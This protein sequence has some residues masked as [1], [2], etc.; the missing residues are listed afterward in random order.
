MFNRHQFFSL[1]SCFKVANIG[2][3]SSAYPAMHLCVS[4][5]KLGTSSSPATPGTFFERANPGHPGNFFVYFPAPGQKMM[6]KFPG[7]GAKFSQ[8]PRIC[9]VLSLQKSLKIKK[10]TRQQNHS[11]VFKYSSLDIQLKQWN[12]HIH[13]YIVLNA[14]VH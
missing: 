13:K 8:T 10:T 12:I 11:K 3:L 4:Q 14:V 1:P 9:S 5:F 2:G 7:G 6:V